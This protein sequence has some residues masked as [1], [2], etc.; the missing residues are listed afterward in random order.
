MQFFLLTGECGEAG[1]GPFEEDDVG[2]R[3]VF[4]QLFFHFFIHRVHV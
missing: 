3:F 1:E 2:N 4:S